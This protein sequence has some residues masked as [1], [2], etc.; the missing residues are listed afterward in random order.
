MPALCS[1]GLAVRLCM[2]GLLF[3]DHH[4][5]TVR[6]IPTLGNCIWQSLIHET[7]GHQ[8]RMAGKVVSMSQCPSRLH[9][10]CELG[11]EAIVWE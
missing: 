8:C 9:S 5:R 3:I 7:H 11:Q 2:P 10:E 6:T 1:L 4:C